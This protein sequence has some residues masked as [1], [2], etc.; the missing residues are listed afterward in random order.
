MKRLFGI[1][2]TVFV[3]FSIF[4]VAAA[5]DRDNYVIGVLS[6]FTSLARNSFHE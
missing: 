2:L 4:S 6:T 1:F 5:A 3:C